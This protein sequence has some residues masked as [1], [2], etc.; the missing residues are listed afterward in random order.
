MEFE[1]ILELKQTNFRVN[2]NF[3]TKMKTQ[4]A[5]R[6]LTA[7]CAIGAIEQSISR[8]RFHQTT[9]NNNDERDWLA[10]GINENFSQGAIGNLIGW[11]KQFDTIICLFKL[12]VELKMISKLIKNILKRKCITSKRVFASAKLIEN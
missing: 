10:E 1:E 12:L 11:R 5:K 6:Y 9:E 8:A 4:H 7:K 3:I 2:Q